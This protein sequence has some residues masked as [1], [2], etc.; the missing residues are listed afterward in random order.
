LGRLEEAYSLMPEN[1]RYSRI[2]SLYRSGPLY[3][4]KLSKIYWNNL[5][6]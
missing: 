5:R 1:I 4:E 3:I 2:L 6:S